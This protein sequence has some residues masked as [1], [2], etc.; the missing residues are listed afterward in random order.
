VPDTVPHPD[1][2]TVLLW[3]TDRVPV[4]EP[5]GQLEEDTLDVC[6]GVSV[7]LPEPQPLCV[8][9]WEALGVEDRVESTDD[10]TESVG[11]TEEEV[12]VLELTLGERVEVMQ[13]VGLFDCVLEAL[14]EPLLV[15][16]KDTVVQPELE[17]LLL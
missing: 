2:D 3:L 13:M 10:V 1:A 9:D 8:P 5:E 4:T 14:K 17:I 6:E 12:V 11:V 16:D 15:N 7:T